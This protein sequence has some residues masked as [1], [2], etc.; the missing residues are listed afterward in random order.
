VIVFFLFIT[1]IGS[2]I[3]CL[4]LL[5]TPIVPILSGLWIKN[6]LD[7]ERAAYAPRY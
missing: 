3:A 6:D 7:K 2:P 5:V 4:M 1:I